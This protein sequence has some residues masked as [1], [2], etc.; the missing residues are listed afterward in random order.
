M[1]KTLAL[2][3]AGALLF[4]LGACDSAADPL[5]ILEPASGAAVSTPFTVRV[6]MADSANHHIHLWFD[7]NEANYQD[8][9]G[10]TAQ[11]TDVPV[12]AH[13]MTVSLRNADHSDAGPR[14]E[15]PITVGDAPPPGY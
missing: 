13:K 14:V 6:K 15:I 2:L 9:D 5:V 7:G 12:G 8:V 1:G 4:G 10:D 11:V 3:A